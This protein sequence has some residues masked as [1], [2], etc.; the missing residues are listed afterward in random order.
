MG[1]V[2]RRARLLVLL[3]DRVVQL[4]REV[5][6][7]R[8][9][10]LLHAVDVLLRGGKGDGGEGMGWWRGRRLGREKGVMAGGEGR[11]G[12]DCDAKPG[13]SADLRITC[14]AGSERSTTLPISCD[15]QTL[16]FIRL[17]TTRPVESSWKRWPLAS[18]R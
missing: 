11:T 8:H 10:H 15:A 16:W 2:W 1:E 14:A 17:F 7:P 13:M 4:E 5:L 18:Q 3:L 12:C 6:L 9:R